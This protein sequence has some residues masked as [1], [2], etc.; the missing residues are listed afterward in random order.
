MPSRRCRR[1]RCLEVLIK[2]KRSSRICQKVERVSL[3]LFVVLDCLFY[4]CSFHSSSFSCFS[5]R[6]DVVSWSFIPSGFGQQGFLE[7]TGAHYH[8]KPVFQPG[9][10]HI[11]A[12]YPL[13][14]L[15]ARGG[16]LYH[17]VLA[18]KPGSWALSRV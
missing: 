17:A 11:P 15:A 3:L 14:F 1:T 18:A 12:C 4:G 6:R 2:H 16:F 7:K 13:L 9:C 5:S 10:P 8:D